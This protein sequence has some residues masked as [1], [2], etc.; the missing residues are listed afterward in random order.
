M[1]R[2]RHRRFR[3]YRFWSR[4]ALASLVFAACGG[5]PEISLTDGNVEGGGDL[6][7]ACDADAACSANLLCSDE[8][9]CER[10]CG[11]LTGNGCGDEACL[12]DGGCSEGLGDD[13]TSDKNCNGALVCSSVQHC[14]VACEPGLAHVCKGGDVCREDGTCP[15]DRDIML[16]FGGAD[17]GEDPGGMGGSGSCIDVEVTFEPQVP[18][19]LLLIDRSGSMNANNFGA[20]VAQAVT[21]GT[22]ALG[23]CPNNNDWRW[24]VVR[25]VLFNPDK[26]IVKPLE[27]KVRFG[28]SL[29]SSD[30]GQLDLSTTNDLEDII[31]NKMCPTLIEVPIALG[32]HQAMLDEFKCSD[33]FDDTPTG[34]S[35]VA[36]AETLKNFDEPGP[37]VIVLATDG[38]PDNC[39][40][41]DFSGDVPAHCKVDVATLRAQIQQD[42]VDTAE[43]IHGEDITIHVIN[44]S[45]PGEATLQ[46][47]L[48]DV[49]MAGGGEVYPG[50]SPGALS[51][52]FD[53]IINGVRSCVVDLDGEIAEGK[54][55]TGTVTLDGEELGLDDENG[56]QV[57][58]PS[59]IELLGTACEA[60][61]SGDH[62]I[63]IKFP[64]ES[65]E[66]VVH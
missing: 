58:T 50:F 28:L 40:C 46:Q 49:A 52:A 5:N 59:Q 32:N 38:E 3:S 54:E 8:G 66:P 26:G 53:D 10:A 62:D 33:I 27:D 21:D 7:D 41:P 14:S 11:E 57:N 19:V 31:P 16:G 45:T 34:E 63:D 39:D 56:W 12:P 9:V 18:T 20:A 1:S 61:K 44:V 2:L 15:T 17:P 25:D 35:L 43:Q 51:T 55:S 64:C 60:I 47:H 6:G 37:K 13:C 4:A 48:A 29:Y 22:Y 30:N 42:V 23:D 65:F 36:A 24:N